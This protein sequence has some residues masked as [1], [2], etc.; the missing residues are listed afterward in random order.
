MRK[1]FA[2]IEEF[3]TTPIERGSQRPS[4]LARAYLGTS[5]AESEA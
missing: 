3:L 5:L 4:I 2:Q 1:L